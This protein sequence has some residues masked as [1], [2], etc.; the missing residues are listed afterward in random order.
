MK[1]QIGVLTA[2]RAEFGLLKPLIKRLIDEEF[3]DTKVLVTGAHLSPAFGYTYKE[4]EEAGIPIDVRIE[5]VTEG[6][7]PR[8]ISNNMA[9]AMKGFGEYFEKN[10]LDLL[11]VLGD[12]YETLA[13]CIAAMNAEIPMA[14]IHGGEATEGLIDEAVRHSITKMSQLHFVTTDVYRKRVIQMG[15]HPNR[16]FN[17][18]ALGAENTKNTDFISCE[19][20]GKDLGIDLSGEY[21]VVTFHPVTLEE[22]SGVEQVDRLM[23][24]MDAFPQMKYIITKANADAGG[25]RI[26][27]RIDDYAASHDNVV[28]VTS[29]GVRRYL[30]A[31]KGSV[32][33]IGNSSSGIMEAPCLHVPTVNIGDRQ[34]GRLMPDSV[35][36]CEPDTQE[37]IKTIKKAV[38]HDFREAVRNMTNPFGDG[39]TSARISDIIRKSFETQGKIPVMKAFYDIEV[40][41]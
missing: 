9:M 29:L 22:N 36:C 35:L 6:D 31:V 21:A 20:L 12:R 4:I 14:H 25:R 10:R 33:V 15:E 26:N 24:A 27:M 3:C 32:V 38:S 41:A 23:E 34:K 17:V 7:S 13:V 37:I 5:C 30:S 16:V 11:I 40:D 1:K 18:G 39:N 19:D 8:D 2:T 28:A